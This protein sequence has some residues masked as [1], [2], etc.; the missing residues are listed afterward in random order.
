MDSL[1]RRKTIM[2]GAIINLVGAILQ[3]AAQHLGMI[4]VGRILAGWAVG[5]LSMSVPIYQSE[6]AHPKTRGRLNISFS[7]RI[8]ANSCP[9]LIVGL[10]Q[11]MIG[12][13]F[14]VSTWVGY[15]SSKVPDTSS[16]SWR[17]PLAFQ[18]VPCLMIICGIMF[19]PESPRYLVE[20]DRSDEALRVLHKL[21][22]DGTNEDWINQEFNEIKLT[23]DAE[24]A[25]TAPGWAIMFKVP[26]WRTRLMHATLIQVFTQMTG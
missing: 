5:V 7:M 8:V 11:Q 15:G 24:K 13:G 10:A 3:T 22:Y 23:I 26:V 14:I 16:F 18:C 9:G 20:T 6:C 25:I 12:V 19:F 21:H 17:F 1:G 2:V 4:L